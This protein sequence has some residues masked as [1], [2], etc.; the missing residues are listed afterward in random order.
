MSKRQSLTKTTRFE[1]FKRDAFQCQYCGGKAPDVVLEVDHLK[2]VASGGDNEMI[3]LVTS[4][5]D[6]NAGKGAKHLDDQ[7]A[8]EKQRR[9][10][11]ELN[12]RRQQLEMMLQWRDQMEGLE[13]F[14]LEA[15]CE[16]WEEQ[17]YGYHLNE[18]G[19]QKV[20]RWLKKYG[21]NELLDALDQS[22][23]RYLRFDGDKPTHESVNKALEY[24]PRI[25]AI[26]RKSQDKPWLKDLFYVRGILRNRLNYVNER[27]CLDLLERAHLA[28]AS[29]EML[30][31]F[32]CQVTS[33]SAFRDEVLNF[34]E[35]HEDPDA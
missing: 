30:K 1:V 35:D 4:C 16:R 23:E 15:F 8:V 2:P 9:Q 10:I 5:R 18:T 19:R 31:S 26:Q 27:Q 32:S 24:V 33:W 7:S 34:L 29:I 25:C 22:C 20:R 21:L 6:C 11:E 12:E 3:N 14:Q 13:N 17:A 28:G